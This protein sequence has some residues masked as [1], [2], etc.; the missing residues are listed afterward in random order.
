MQTE[1]S[2]TRRH[3]AFRHGDRVERAILDTATELLAQRP[4]ASI[5]ISELA[6]GAGI[7][8]SAFYFYFE[9]REAVLRELV[10]RISD[11]LYDASEVFLLRRSGETPDAAVRRALAGLLAVWRR[12]GA[13]LRAIVHASD[14]DAQL[15]EFWAAVARRFVRA[16]AELVQ[17]EREV[18][19]AL[20]GPPPAAAL[21]G[22]LV[23]MNDRAFHEASLR[24][25]GRSDRALLDALAAVW[26]RS[27]YGTE[28][29]QARVRS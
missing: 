13:V 4:L 24:R 19:N 8:R 22:V 16:T 15:R 11:E 25:G 27:I 2:G 28:P 5:R 7:S 3:R 10:E 29:A 6:R 9:S 1:Y 17:R 21:A 12:H 23:A 26:L 20:P 18:G 14:E